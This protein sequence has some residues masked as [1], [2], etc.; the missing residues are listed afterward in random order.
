MK[1]SIRMGAI[2]GL[3]CLS[4]T[5]CDI[6]FVNKF[7]GKSEA[8]NVKPSAVV[9]TFDHENVE[10]NEVFIYA[11]VVRGAYEARYGSGV[12]D[13]ETKDSEDIMASM[14]DITKKDIVNDIRTTKA[15]AKK[16]SEYGISLSDD[17]II[18]IRTDSVSFFKNLTDEQIK[19]MNIDEELVEK[20]YSENVLANRVH[21]ALM[22]EGTTEVSDEEARMTTFF[23]LYFPTYMEDATGSAVPY[24]EEQ[25]QTVKANADEALA[26]YENPDN[27][28]TN[29]ELFAKHNLK[30]GGERTLSTSEMVSE[31]GEEVV[32]GLYSLENGEHTGVVETEFGYHI[33]TMIEL[34][35]SVETAKVKEELLKEKQ[36]A[37]VESKLSEWLVDLSPDWSYDTAVDKDVLGNIHFSET[38]E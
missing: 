7:F 23:D 31:Y 37:Y 34:T 24:N 20:V 12:W 27:P 15:M 35:N 13:I 29:D 32:N 3:L 4:L 30:F 2:C 21:N 28:L 5:A 33:F 10:L 38:G 6:P 26:E 36:K 16:A 1:K 14:E 18:D 25:K 19:K 9:F 11:E 17:D 8:D 22:E